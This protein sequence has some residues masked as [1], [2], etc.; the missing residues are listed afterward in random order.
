MKKERVL[1]ICIHNS[2]RSQMDEAWLRLPA[3]DRYAVESAGCDFCIGS[4]RAG[5]ADR[6]MSV[7]FGFDEKHRVVL[8]FFRETL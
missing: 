3:A 4:M 6:G 1:F 7:S 5:T 2:T 8:A